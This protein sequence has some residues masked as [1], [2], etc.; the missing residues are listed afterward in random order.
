MSTDKAR[1]ELAELKVKLGEIDSKGAVEKKALQL[2]FALEHSTVK[3][4]DI[5]RERSVSIK[6][7]TIDMYLEFGTY[8]PACRYSGLRCTR[9]GKIFKSGKRETLYLYSMSYI[10]S[11]KEC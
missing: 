8:K 2:K 7:D 9:V 6:V 11:V 5:V 4:G 1:D 10:I 3:V